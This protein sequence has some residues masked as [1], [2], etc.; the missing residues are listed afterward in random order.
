M[1][2]HP[3]HYENEQQRTH[4]ICVAGLQLQTT[5]LPRQAQDIV[6]MGRE[7]LSTELNY[8]GGDGVSRGFG[9]V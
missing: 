7:E 3:L 8:S 2:H 9:A 5:A 6:F 1:V 4:L